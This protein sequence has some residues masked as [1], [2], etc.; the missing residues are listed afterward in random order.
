MR[1]KFCFA[2]HNFVWFVFR[3]ASQRFP[4]F[5]VGFAGNSEF[6]SLFI[7]ILSVMFY[8]ALYLSCLAV[9]ICSLC[10]HGLFACHF[11]CHKLYAVFLW[12]Y[13]I[14]F[15][16]L[17]CFPF[18][19]FLYLSALHYRLQACSLTFVNLLLDR[20]IFLA[21]NRSYGCYIKLCSFLFFAPHCLP[22]FVYLFTYLPLHY[23]SSPAGPRLFYLL[24]VILFAFPVWIF[25][26]Y[27][28]FSLIALNLFL[29]FHHQC[30]IAFRAWF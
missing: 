11:A 7:F 28:L 13:Y 29:Y 23:A 16:H 26:L 12:L 30:L 9:Q 20:I 14:V 19:K 10:S 15:L 8:L 6:L 5:Y 2:G 1:T 27:K 25:L 4:S 24:Y 3:P 22:F 18:S 17:L 21:C